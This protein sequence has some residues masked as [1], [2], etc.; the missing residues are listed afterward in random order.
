MIDYQSLIDQVDE[1]IINRDKTVIL[2]FILITAVLAVGFGMTATDSGTSQFSEGV[3]A[4]EAFEDV[5]DNFEREPFGTGTGTTTLIQRDRNVLT[6]SAVLAMLRAQHRIQRDTSQNVVSTNSVAQTIATEIDPT[7]TTL[8]AQI[9]AVERTPQS[10]V[11]T[12]TRTIVRTQ[13]SVR[14]RLSDDLNERDPSASATIATITHQVAGTSD[15]AGTQSGS[16]LTSLQ[17]EATFIVGST[18]GDITVFGSGIISG[19]LGGVITDSLI[20]V[21]PA[22]VILIFIFLIIAYRDPIDLIIGLVS[23]A[24]TIAWTF[25]F[26]GWARIEFTQILIAIPPLLLAVGIDFGIHA[27]NRYR[28]ER[29]TGEDIS[30]SMRTTTDQLLPAFS[31]V[32]GTTV[33]GFA[34]NGVS[35]LAPVREFGLVAAVGIIFTL[36]IF[37]IFLPAFKHLLDRK[38]VEYS[39]PSFGTTPIGRAGSVG[40]RVLGVGVVIAR[41]SPYIFLLAILILTAALGGYGTGVETR[42][43]TDDFLPPEETPG[44]LEELPEP[45]APGEYTVT[46]TTNYLENTFESSE[47]DTVT[48]YVEGSMR[49]GSTLEILHKTNQDPPDSFVTA[50]RESQPQSILTVIDQYERESA[51]F[52]RLISAKDQNG[53]GIPDHDL[54]IVYDQLFASSYGDQARLYL[55]DD[56][57][58]TRLIYSVKAEKSQAAIT[59]DT[60]QLATEIRMESTA[61]GS[62]VVR[63]AVSDVIA[64]SAYTSLVI[65][66]LTAAVFLVAIYWLLENRPGLGIANIL[67]VLLTIAGLA[68]TMRYLDIPFNVLTGTTLSVGIGLGIDYSAHLVHRFTEEYRGEVDRFEALSVSVRGTGGALAGSM[69][70]TTSGTGVL[71]LAI[72]PILGQFGLLIALSV[73]YSFIASIFVL[74]AA[75]IGWTDIRRQLWIDK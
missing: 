70:T 12:V 33:L 66:V 26:M 31:I 52:R 36:L 15:D 37:G 57:T 60:R 38:R 54:G 24:M 30:S 73:L 61:T 1:W 21:V 65:A 69:L 16:P 27:V 71:I 6:K 49:Q 23:L 19:E 4:Q 63:K 50:E 10:G 25:G 53:N 59:A 28:E 35:D 34:A 20:I 17:R 7:A 22:A 18:S 51:S 3:P 8:S 5:N 47:D 67:P 62:V 75:L 58:A 46:K 43:T 42:F 32:T 44:Y 45:F 48:V 2:I 72:T 39:I 29:V 68:S 40:G 55:T 74:P 14:S 64:E 9:D 11:R 56:Y 13:P 41:R